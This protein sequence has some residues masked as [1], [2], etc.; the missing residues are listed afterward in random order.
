MLS[1]HGVTGGSEN[2]VA[3]SLIQSFHPCCM[4]K[5]EGSELLTVSVIN[6]NILQDSFT[7]CVKKAKAT[8]ATDD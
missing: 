1:T 4:S 3:H 8:I 6:G 7:M 5:E 2:N